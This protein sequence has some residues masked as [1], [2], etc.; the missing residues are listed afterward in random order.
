[1]SEKKLLTMGSAL[2]AVVLFIR[3]TVTFFLTPFIITMLGERFYG[4]WILIG[5]FVGYYGIFDFGI[6]GAVIRYVSREIGAGRQH[7]VNY[8]VNSAFFM[9]LSLGLLIILVSFGA[10]F[11]A[12][13]IIDDIDNLKFFRFAVIIMGISIGS[14]FPLRV[15]DGFLGAHM[16]FD[17]KRYVELF[18]LFFRTVA[19]VIFLKLGY[20]IYGLALVSAL[21]TLLELGLKTGICFRMS[22]TFRFGIM[23]AS[24]D[25]IKEMMDYALA[26]FINIIN[27]I[28]S[29]QLAPYI[30]VLVSS[31]TTVAYYGVA[32][33]LVNYFS[34]FF[35][36]TQG[37][38]FPLFSKRDGSGDL[39]GM[40]HWL[41]LGSRISTILAAT[42]GL[43]LVLYGRQ[44][45]GRWL[46]PAFHISYVYTSILIIPLVISFGMFP[47]VF[48][49]NGTGRHR[50]ATFLDVLRSTFILALSLVLGH[51]LG[52]V[53]VAIGTAI[54]CL[55]FDGLIKPYF[56]CLTIQAKP[57][58][59]YGVVLMSIWKVC[60]LMLPVWLI[61]GKCIQENYLSLALICSLHICVIILF[62]PFLLISRQERQWFIKYI[63][64]RY[65]WL[66]KRQENIKTS[67]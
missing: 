61:L 28:V 58:R 45:L 16:R 21:S 54:P 48:V 32:L 55:I 6:G 24:L 64:V 15:F 42:G 17:L 13:F 30:V 40:K 5:T 41:V 25:R 36:S 14:S 67:L 2:S 35:R 20:G 51:L 29:N 62:G 27:N 63:S 66:S 47:S 31:V 12:Q 3:I 44:F 56:A 37:V 9:L 22:S 57:L 39:S 53:G 46:G 18:E 38:F 49:L 52:A 59:Y 33:T 50:L 65:P 7:T 26:N 10:A 4:I 34:E 1:M 11:F 43:L 60:I 8:Y 19:V 23:Y